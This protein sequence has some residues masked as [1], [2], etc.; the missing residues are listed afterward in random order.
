MS[1]VPL[2]TKA[3]TLKAFVGTLQTA[4]VP[5]LDYFAVR[6]WKADPAQIVARLQE[7]FRGRRV[8]VRSSAQGEDGLLESMAGAFESV[9]SVDADSAND[10]AEAIERVVCEYSED[11][12][13]QVLVQRMVDQVAVSAVA[14]THVLSDGAP[15]Y[16]LNYDDES[17][18]TDAITG[19]TGVHKTVMIHREADPA[20]VESERVRAWLGMIR[21]V[22]GRTEPVPLDLEFVQ[23]HAGTIHLLQ[24]RRISAAKNWGPE[25]ADTVRDAIGHFERFVGDRSR[26]RPGLVGSRTIFGE[27]T[28]WNPAEIIGT[29]PRPLAVSLYRRLIT[30]RVW[31]LARAEMGYRNP[32]GESLMVMI[33]GRPFID[34][35]NSFNSFLPS[36]LGEATAESVVEAWL[37][38]LDEHPEFHD[39]VEF[40]VCHTAMDFDFD[41]SVRSRY[42]DRLDS[43]CV[44]DLR[45]HLVSFTRRCV[46]LGPGGTLDNALARIRHLEEL[47]STYDVRWPEPTGAV[48]FLA[49]ARSLLDDCVVWGSLPFSV[50]ARHAFIAEALLRS[51]VTRGAL[52]PSRFEALK[53]SLTTVSGELSRDFKMAAEG[54]ISQDEF[55]RV[56]GHLRPGTYDV[57][58][59]RYDQRPDIF[60]QYWA[61]DELHSAPS[62]ELSSEEQGHLED[63][64]DGAGL[65]GVASSDLMTYARRAI[66]GRERS[67]FVFTRSLSDAMESIVA[68]G[69]RI[70]LT[71]DDV[72]HLSLGA[73]LEPRDGPLL[74]S[75]LGHFRSM[76]EKSRESSER[77]LRLRLS[78]LIRGVRDVRVIPLHR[79]APNF[80][81]FK[82]IEGDAVL[83][84][85]RMSTFPDLRGHIVCIENA[86]PGFDWVFTRGIAALVTKFGGTNSHMAIRCAEFG[87]PAAIGVGE[88]TFGRLVEARRIEINCA[89]KILRP[90]YG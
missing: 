1:R 53:R 75:E 65:H 58:S 35:R 38:R 62:F 46:E 23:D 70:G 16:V 78:Y 50:I 76:A 83:I 39:K 48:D 12:A 30:D 74:G 54:R 33:G 57:L 52:T 29:N 34:V 3:E 47:Q 71:R 72:S 27:M 6:E 90:I 22:E 66:V 25:L 31:R 64:L 14:T 5:S 86:D 28:D 87:L 40:E 84:H 67:K 36:T 15:Y 85:S 42:G 37:D 59:L 2:G 45:E 89:D 10:L 60:D 26:R 24:V 63:L 79:G 44:A 17:G 69:E 82:R 8:A 20:M 68:W 11:D 32:V 19:G 49:R 7:A 41:A 61:Q 80:I 4:S 43:E 81:T 13:H 73:V 21:E 88:Q 9:L 77:S 18:K 56:Y 55:L 51:A